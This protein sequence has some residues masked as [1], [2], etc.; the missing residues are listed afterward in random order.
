[1]R[2]NICFL[3]LLAIAT[4]ASGLELKEVPLARDGD[5]LARAIAFPAAL[6]LAVAVALLVRIVSRVEDLRRDGKE[7]SR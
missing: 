5:T 7:R 4:L 3:A 2:L 6:I 1:V